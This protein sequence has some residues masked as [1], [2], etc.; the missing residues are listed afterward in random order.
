MQAEKYFAFRR[1]ARRARLATARCRC[2][3]ARRNR[4]GRKE[5]RNFENA[6]RRS[7]DRRRAGRQRL[8]AGFRIEF[9]MRPRAA[10]RLCGTAFARR[11]GV[12]AF[13]CPKREPLRNEAIST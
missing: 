5:I 3:F 1:S 2:E 11:G 9:Q 12:E 8:N 7:E 10:L 4:R 13:A 6:G